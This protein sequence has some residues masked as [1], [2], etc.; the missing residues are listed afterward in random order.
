MELLTAGQSNSIESSNIRP[1][2]TSSSGPVPV[3][4]SRSEPEDSQKASQDMDVQAIS[5]LRRLKLPRP[6]DFT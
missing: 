2:T 1:G 4:T 6:F 5:L 3:H